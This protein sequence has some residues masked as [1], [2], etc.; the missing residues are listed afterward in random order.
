MNENINEDLK[1]QLFGRIE[2]LKT[3]I[4]EDEKT[5]YIQE[6]KI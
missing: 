6:M 5:L 1:F 2:S 4:Y 3:S